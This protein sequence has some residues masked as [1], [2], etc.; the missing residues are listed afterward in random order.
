MTAFFIRFDIYEQLCYI[1]YALKRKSTLDI[2]PSESGIVETDD[3]FLVK[4]HL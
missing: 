1:D 4:E 3:K 2:Y